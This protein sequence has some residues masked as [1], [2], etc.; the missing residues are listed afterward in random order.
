[1]LLDKSLAR[2]MGLA[3]N[4]PTECSVSQLIALRE[5]SWQESKPQPADEGV[6]AGGSRGRSPTKTRTAL[7]SVD[8]SYD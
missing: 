5:S 2:S 7:Q 6:V 1:M 8:L 3:S 4:L